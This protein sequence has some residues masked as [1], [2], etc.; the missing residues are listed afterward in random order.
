M[1]QYLSPN[2]DFSDAARATIRAAKDLY[3]NTEANAINTALPKVGLSAEGSSQT[4]PPHEHADLAGQEAAG[5]RR[6]SS[7]GLHQLDREWHV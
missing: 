6:K 5:A 1:T 4:T 3:G 7:G 2:S